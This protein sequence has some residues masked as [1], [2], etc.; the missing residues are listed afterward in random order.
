VRHIPIVVWLAA[1]QFAQHLIGASIR[2]F[3]QLAVWD[4]AIGFGQCPVGILDEKVTIG[5]LLWQLLFD[6]KRMVTDLDRKS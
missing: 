1:G 4:G 2:D 3:C 6:L 5:A